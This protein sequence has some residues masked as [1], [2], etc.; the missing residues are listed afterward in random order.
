MKVRAAALAAIASVV[1][2]GG[3][4]YPAPY[5]VYESRPVAERV[6]YGVVESM[7]LYRGGSGAPIGLGT[8]L[9]GIAK[10]RMPATGIA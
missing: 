7:Q 9:G 5:V 3:C 4:A 8:I 2:I 1:I 6:E 10:R